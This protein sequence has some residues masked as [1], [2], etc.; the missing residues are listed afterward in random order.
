MVMRYT[1]K[2]I[3]IQNMKCLHTVECD[4]GHSTIKKVDNAMLLFRLYLI[5]MNQLYLF[6]I[7][8]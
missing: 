4:Q 3:D 5:G 7:A 6:H 2:V 8:W 1:K